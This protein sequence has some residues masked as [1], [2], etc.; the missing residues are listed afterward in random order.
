V[1]AGLRSFDNTM[2]EEINRIVTDRLSDLLFVTE[3]SGMA[4]LKAEGI[5]DN[6]VF[7][8]G[9]IM[10]DSLVGNLKL[11]QQSK[12]LTRL[13]VTPGE[14]AAM[15]LH[16][17]ANVDDESMLR[18]LL[19]VLL[20]IAVRLPV[21]FPCHPRTMK[22]LEKFGLLDEFDRESLNIIAPLG[23]LDFLKLQ[24]EAKFVLTD[25]GGVQ[26]ETTYLK[27]PCLTLRKNTERPITIEIGS[28]TL[29]GLDPDKI[30]AAVDLI[31]DGSYK[32]GN[33]PI[34]WDGQTAVRI[35]DVLTRIL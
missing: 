28:N 26:E 21:V 13:N 27:I 1:E 25:S 29:T 22:N 2:P 17:P 23:Y 19:Y 10:I 12:I 7:L 34:L 30:T 6:R 18:K 24:S 11:A 16:R 5:D 9:N 3:E 20:E 4:N 31:L 14:Y 33:I 35:V 32:S 15:T 8:T